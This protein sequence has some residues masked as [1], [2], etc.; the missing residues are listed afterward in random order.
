M[1][2]QK[3]KY[4]IR[5]V[6]YLSIESDFEK[7]LTGGKDVSKALKIPLAFTSKILLELA[8][9]GLITSIKGPGGGFFLS[10]EN[11]NFPIFKIVEVMGDIDYFTSCG[12]GLDECSEL[13]P[14]PI[15]DTFKIGRDK[16]LAL[17]KNKT[18]GDLGKEIVESELFL[19]R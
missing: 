7:G 10:K 11:R 8:R 3:C 17:F 12:L 18:I 19:V 1:L 4:A 16:L 5:S 2:S 6:L 13:R 9:A 14:C 15:H